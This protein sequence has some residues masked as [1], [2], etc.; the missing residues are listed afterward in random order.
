VVELKVGPAPDANKQQGAWETGRRV[1]GPPQ[2]PSN[3]CLLSSL[4][5]S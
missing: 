2:P 5:Q 1:S 4:S 3:T